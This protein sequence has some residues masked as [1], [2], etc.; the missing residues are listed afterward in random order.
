MMMT[1]TTTHSKDKQEICSRAQGLRS[2][3]EG[4]AKYRPMHA[5]CDSGTCDACAL[6][7]AARARAN[8]RLRQYE[9]I[10]TDVEHGS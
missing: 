9:S 8:E 6:K 5:A 7:W 2:V 3:N 10:R 4:G 1:T